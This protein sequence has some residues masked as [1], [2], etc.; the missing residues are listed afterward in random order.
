[1]ALK[2]NCPRRL[3]N[4]AAEHAAVAM[5]LRDGGSE[6][7]LLFI[8]R[9]EHPLDPWS[10]HMAFPGGRWDPQD[11]DS[12][13]TAIRETAE[14]LNIDLNRTGRFLGGLD[15]LTAVARPRGRELV[16]APYV[17]RL[18]E[19]IL[20]AP[21]SEVRAIHWIEL[22]KLSAKTNRMVLDQTFA[23]RRMSCPSLRV[24]GHVIWGLT[25][26]MFR[27]LEELVQATGSIQKSADGEELAQ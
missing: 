26:R 24:D 10:G 5:L 2:E 13:A 1:M 25:Y 3:E 16:I 18:D 23:G 17:Y 12:Q 11:V 15:E 21:G 27:R 9:A 8:E 22:S 6:V 14:E 7:E 20:P 4:A 19:T